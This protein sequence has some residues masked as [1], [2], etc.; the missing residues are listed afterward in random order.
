ME[1]EK[2]TKETLIEK[3]ENIE[4]DYILVLDFEATCYDKD[5]IKSE[6]QLKTC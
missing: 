3:E 6:K 4:F 1:K 5:D 2:S